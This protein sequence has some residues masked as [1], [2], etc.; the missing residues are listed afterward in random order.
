MEDKSDYFFPSDLVSNKK[1][2]YTKKYK[3]P[4]KWKS[5]C[6]PGDSCLLE[7]VFQTF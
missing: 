3:I 7:I 6:F 2:Q 5:F 1:E 4:N